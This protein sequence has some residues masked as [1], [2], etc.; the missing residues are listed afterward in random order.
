MGA[1]YNPENNSYFM[2]L[3]LLAGFTA[4]SLVLS[5]TVCNGGKADERTRR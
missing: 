2:G 1:T 5:L 4:A 3:T